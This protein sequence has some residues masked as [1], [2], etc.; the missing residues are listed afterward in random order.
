MRVATQT[1]IVLGV[2]MIRASGAVSRPPITDPRIPPAANSGNSRLACRVSV[3]VP[4]IPHRKTV[5]TRIAI[6]TVTHR[7]Q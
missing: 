5:C 6:V 1:T 4:A 7:T 2:P 3:T